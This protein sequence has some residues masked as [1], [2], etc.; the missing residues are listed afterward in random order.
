MSAKQVWKFPIEKPSDRI[1][2]CMPE[3]ATILAFDTQREVMCLWAMVDPGAHG[4]D[5]TFRVA[6]S[7][8]EIP[9]SGVPCYA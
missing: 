1:I 3:G 5:R 4:V 2:M 7:K 6:G 9:P 8:D